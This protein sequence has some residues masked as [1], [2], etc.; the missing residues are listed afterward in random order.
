VAV[1]STDVRIDYDS[2]ADVVRVL[3]SK[4]QDASDG[5]VSPKGEARATRLA[6]PGVRVGPY[7]ECLV[8][9]RRQLRRRLA[10]LAR[11]RLEESVEGCG[12]RG[13][14][15]RPTHQVV[16]DPHDVHRLR[17]QAVTVVREPQVALDS[18]R[19]QLG[20]RG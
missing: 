14:G 17:H 11:P 5:P 15:V 18:G 1:I 12:E 4:Q 9:K 16:H 19:G 13:L 8:V 2:L 7:E 20:R 10:R 6:G 3:V